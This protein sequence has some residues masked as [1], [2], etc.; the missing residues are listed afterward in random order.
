[1]CQPALNSKPTK[2][3][4]A[5]TRCKASSDECWAV[6][7]TDRA[8]L[9]ATHSPA[10]G[11]GTKSVPRQG[12][13]TPLPLKRSPPV[14]FKRLLGAA[15]T[16]ALSSFPPCHRNGLLSPRT[17]RL[18]ILNEVLCH[19]VVLHGLAVLAIG[20]EWTHA[21]RLEVAPIG[22]VDLEVECVVGYQGEEEI[23]RIDA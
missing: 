22:V 21:A 13:N 18:G 12:H 7:L 23:T 14:S 5:M 6:R 3:R 9:R 10:Q 11:C 20:P 4:G 8:K 19:L 2:A 17:Q 16:R 15:A 1:M